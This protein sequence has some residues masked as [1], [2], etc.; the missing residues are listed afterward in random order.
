MSEQ[1]TGNPE[2]PSNKDFVQKNIEFLESRGFAGQLMIPTFKAALEVEPRLKA[3]LFDVYR[4]VPNQHVLAGASAP[5]EDPERGLYTILWNPEFFGAN[6]EVLTKALPIELKGDPY[7]EKQ[8]EMIGKDFHDTAL[9]DIDQSILLHELGHIVYFLD[10]EDN[11]KEIEASR[12]RDLE[13]LPVVPG[14]LIA[15]LPDFKERYETNKDGVRDQLNE[16]Y[17]VSSLEELYKVQ[18]NAYH[19]MPSEMIPDE[20]AAK[21]FEHIREKRNEEQG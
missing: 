4:T 8:C 2:K 13:G 17:G 9:S 6:E 14:A 10:N 20:F 18:M 19:N 11:F 16:D 12:Q 1:E 15:E 5:W 7:I 3:V 21:V